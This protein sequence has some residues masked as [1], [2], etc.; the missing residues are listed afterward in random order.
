[1]TG[2]CQS[3]EFVKTIYRA[4]VASLVQQVAQALSAWGIW[5]D[6]LTELYPQPAL[7]S[8]KWL[9]VPT[10]SFSG[11]NSARQQGIR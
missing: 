11:N 4:A 7:G 2:L 9:K 5:E 3:S 10:L 8:P 1:M 6:L